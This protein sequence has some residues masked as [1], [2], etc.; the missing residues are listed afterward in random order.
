MYTGKRKKV[1]FAF[2]SIPVYTG[3]TLQNLPFSVMRS[4]RK[5]KLVSPSNDLRTALH[6]RCG[7]DAFYE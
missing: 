5:I 2:H 3:T 1:A 4:K 7:K 6:Y